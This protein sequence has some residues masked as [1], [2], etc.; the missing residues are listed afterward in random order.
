M[1][2]DIGRVLSDEPFSLTFTVE[3]SSGL[4]IPMEGT[5]T[6]DNTVYHPVEARLSALELRIYFNDPGIDRYDFCGFE[7]EITP[8]IHLADGTEIST[9]YHTRINSYGFYGYGP[10]PYVSF[11]AEDAD[12]ERLFIDPGQVVSITFGNLE[13][14]VEH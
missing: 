4:T 3:E 13:I 12:G 6:L 9:R 7:D 14:P 1:S 10:Y 5:I 11:R 8:V 2:Y